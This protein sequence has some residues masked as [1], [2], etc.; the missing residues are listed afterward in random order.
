MNALERVKAWALPP[1]TSPVVNLHDLSKL[2]AVVE[3]A[4]AQKEKF[5]TFPDYDGVSVGLDK[6]LAALTEDTP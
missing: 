4:Q 5:G 6:A 1:H 3:A 2:L